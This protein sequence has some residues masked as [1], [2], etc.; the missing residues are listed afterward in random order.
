ML[1]VDID[2]ERRDLVVQATFSVQRGE[3]LA[4]FGPSGSGKTTILETIAGL[5]RPRR[6]TVALRG[7]ELTRAGRRGGNA[8]PWTRRIGLLRQD[9]GLF[10]HLTVRQNITYSR[11]AAAA[12]ERT[13]HGVAERLEILPYLDERPRAL[14]GGQAHRVALAR[15]LLGDDEVVLLDEPY[16]GLDARMR[17][18]LTELV[19]A[20]TSRRSMPSILVAH[21][22]PDAQAFA[23][24][25]AVIDAGQF[26]Q[27]GTPSEVVRRPASRRVAELVGYRG[28]VP[29]DTNGSRGATIGVHPERT[30][31]GAF[32][33]QGAVLSGNIVAARPSGAGWEIELELAES[34][35][36]TSITCRM[37]DPPA[38]G[39]P[40]EV[41]ALDPPLF[42]AD[43]L[44]VPAGQ[45]ATRA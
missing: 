8:P 28:F 30:R 10:P 45:V 15:L 22:L 39:S 26:L 12:T 14:S 25:L 27:I 11:S 36:A 44:I 24:R 34:D 9:P 35:P 17:R 13:V 29:S 20:E 18:V 7:R 23:D 2:V 31:P 42:D 5:V 43:G 16:T 21:E 41:T 19:H 4:L 32:E 1:D 37:D 6:G 33:D 38:L 40:F 3:H